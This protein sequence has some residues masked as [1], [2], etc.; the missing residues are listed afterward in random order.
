[1]FNNIGQPIL[2]GP[3][4]DLIWFLR[5]GFYTSAMC[6][7]KEKESKLVNIEFLAKP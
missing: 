7:G 4:A 1:M 3:S 6:L 5:Y 2:Q